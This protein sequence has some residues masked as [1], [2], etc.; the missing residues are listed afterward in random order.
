MY[1]DKFTYSDGTEFE[2]RV[3]DVVIVVVVV[4]DFLPHLDLFFHLAVL[5]LKCLKTAKN[6]AFSVIFFWLFSFFFLQSSIR[7]QLHTETKRSI[8]NHS[9][10]SI[11][12]CGFAYG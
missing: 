1:F 7:L 3:D 8:L 2:L 4:V 11:E 12:A 5:T 10:Y 6:G 9:F